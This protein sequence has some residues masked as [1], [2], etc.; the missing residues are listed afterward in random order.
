M[1]D[2]ARVI[3]HPPE[4]LCI[5][6]GLGSGKTTALAARARALSERGRRPLVFDRPAIVVGFAVELLA[7]HGQPLRLIGDE[8]RRELVRRLL[9]DG[10]GAAW[11]DSG[12]EIDDPRFVDELAATVLRYQ[13]SFLGAEELFVHADAAGELD[14][15]EALDRFTQRYLDALQGDGEIDRAGAVVTASMAVRDPEILAAERSRFDDLLVDDFQLVD[16][17]TN[18]FLTQLAGRAGSFTVAG[19]AGAAIGSELGWSSRFLASFAKRFD[20][21]TIDMGD[22][23]WRGPSSPEI[24]ETPP[25]DA[26]AHV[27][28]RVSVIGAVGR[29][30]PMVAI[31]DASASAWPAPRPAH[32]WFDPHLFGGP[33]VPSS[34]E[35]DRA[36]L[37]EERRRFAIACTRATERTVLVVPTPP[38]TPLLTEVRPPSSPR[39]PR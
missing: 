20:A 4:P 7:R 35:R 15:W 16:F 31:S 27:L 30:W 13:S 1:S 34:Q 21:T 9:A 33:D 14:R 17:A 12:G 5:T 2:T 23:S 22:E 3:E 32:T 26:H 25:V 36:W 10:G 18:R 19:N 39:R 29:E 28:D 11:G 8:Q 6:G 38:V 37:D 24:V